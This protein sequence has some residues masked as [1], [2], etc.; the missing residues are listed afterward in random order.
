MTGT[1]S[2]P[3]GTRDWAKEEAEALRIER[4]REAELSRKQREK[5]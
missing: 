1:P 3:D 4:A 2:D 5:E